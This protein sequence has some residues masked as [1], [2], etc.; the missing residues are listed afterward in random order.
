M[1]HIQTYTGKWF[2]PLDPNPDDIDIVDIAHSL[3]MLCRY[4][5]HCSRFYSVA[6]HSLLVS[7][8]LEQRHPGNVKLQLM[9]LLHDSAEAYMADVPGPMKKHMPLYKIYEWSLLVKILHKFNVIDQLS[10][11]WRDDKWVEVKAVDTGVLY[12]EALA[13]MLSHGDQTWYK[14]FAPGVLSGTNLD[15]VGLSPTNVERGF[16]ARFHT[17]TNGAYKSSEATTVV[18]D[19]SNIPNEL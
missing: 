16:L 2:S 12:D 15:I 5:G 17:L 6:E 14:T 9:G 13:L 18:M 10:T 19:E 4:N 3:S 11:W 7:S 1:T 8:V